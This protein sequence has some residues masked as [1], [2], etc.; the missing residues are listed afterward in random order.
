M[1]AFTSPIRLR[2]PLATLMAAAVLVVGVTVTVGAA[3]PTINACVNKS[4][5]AVRI[6]QNFL[7]QA[8]C[9]STESFKKWNVTGPTGATGSAWRQWGDRPDWRDWC[10][11]R[12]RRHGCL[13]SARRRNHRR[14]GTHGTN[15][16]DRRHGADGRRHDR[17]HR[18][19][20]RHGSDRRHG[21]DRCTARRRGG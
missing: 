9:K 20:R 7:S 3:E 11:R 1:T 17:T 21:R 6:S 12:D 16:S 14:D 5:K 4:T 13:R 2:R 19:D 18:T 8:N 15:R 10:P